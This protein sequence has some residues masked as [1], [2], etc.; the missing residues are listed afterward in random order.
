M[1]QAGTDSTEVWFCGMR[2]R[3]IF[4]LNNSLE[5]KSAGIYNLTEFYFL[6]VLSL[7]SSFICPFK[8]RLTGS[9]WVTLIMAWW[10]CFVKWDKKERI[11]EVTEM[12]R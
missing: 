3:E 11:A 12:A 7:L 1:D 2:E 5:E 8:A 10:S 4:L 6:S 9:V